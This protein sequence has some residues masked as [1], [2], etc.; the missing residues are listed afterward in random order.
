MNIIVETL[1]CRQTISSSGRGARSPN[2]NERDDE[3]DKEYQGAHDRRKPTTVHPHLGI[4]RL[5]KRDHLL[6]R[7]RRVFRRDVWRSSGSDT[8]PR[9]RVPMRERDPSAFTRTQMRRW[10]RTTLL[11]PLL[12][13]APLQVLTWR[14]WHHPTD[15]LF[16]LTLALSQPTSLCCATTLPN[17]W[18]PQLQHGARL[19][20]RSPTAL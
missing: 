18:L 20:I 11:L 9:K 4:V 1:K 19:S 16:A 3:S 10:T 8:Q 2:D 15:D 5:D 7:R 12:H 6:L 17:T 13:S 14:I